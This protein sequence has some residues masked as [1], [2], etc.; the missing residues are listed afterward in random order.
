M[1]ILLEQAATDLIQVLDNISFSTTCSV[2]GHHRVDAINQF[3][4]FKLKHKCEEKPD[5]TKSM[6]TS[7]I[8]WMQISAYILYIVRSAFWDP[9]SFNNCS[10][11]LRWSWLYKWVWDIGD[12]WQNHSVDANSCDENT[13]LHTEL[14]QFQGNVLGPEQ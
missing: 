5:P 3:R 11:T 9:H 1:N 8:L 7:P 13:I 4:H 10:N 6:L 14:F 12:D 2:F